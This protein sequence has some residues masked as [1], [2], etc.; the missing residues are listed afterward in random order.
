MRFVDDDETR[1]DRR[2]DSTTQRLMCD[3][4]GRKG[5]LL[6]SVVPH[7]AQRRR[8]RDQHAFAKSR[9]HCECSVGLAESYRLREHRAAVE[10]DQRREASGRGA[11][12]RPKRH[13]AYMRRNRLSLANDRAS[14]EAASLL[15]P[16]ETN[17]PHADIQATSGSTSA[18]LNA[19]ASTDA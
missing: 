16:D 10:R 3:Q 8:N 7:T 4:R 1:F 12:M 19:N 15:E 2:R 6:E 5:T 14:D 13:G 17:L 11:L 9:R 18:R